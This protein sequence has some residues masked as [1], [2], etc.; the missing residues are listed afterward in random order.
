[1]GLTGVLPSRLCRRGDRPLADDHPDGR[2]DSLVIFCFSQEVSGV[3]QY[4]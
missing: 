3:I 1:M 2:Q 4:E